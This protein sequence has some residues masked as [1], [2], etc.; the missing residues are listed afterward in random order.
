MENED[1]IIDQ[2]CEKMIPICRNYVKRE[3][4]TSSGDSF[5]DKIF[6]ISERYVDQETRKL[7]L[8]LVSHWTLAIR[9]CMKGK[10]EVSLGDDLFPTSRDTKQIHALETTMKRASLSQQDLKTIMRTFLD[11]LGL[12][13]LTE[14]IVIHKNLAKRKLF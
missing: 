8:Q 11:V 7:S 14:D 5:F 4:T 3:V 10:N 1:D 6:P 9:E 13:A 12:I 2:L